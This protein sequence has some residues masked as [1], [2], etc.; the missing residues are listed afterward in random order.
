ML[1]PIQMA[2]HPHQLP[3][4]PPPPPP[5]PLPLLAGSTRIVAI[6]DFVMPQV[7]AKLARVFIAT[8][9]TNDPTVQQTTCAADMD[10]QN[11]I[12]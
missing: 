2:R 12:R 9:P 10:V 4:P 3:P 8:P 6:D 5:A 11:D 1:I 7:S